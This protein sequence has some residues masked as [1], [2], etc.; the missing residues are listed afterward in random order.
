MHRRTP[1]RARI[2]LA[3]RSFRL[4]VSAIVI[5]IL[6]TACTTPNAAVKSE[7]A[8][9]PAREDG[10]VRIQDAS[11]QFIEV[12]DVTGTASNSTVTAPARVDFRDGAVSQVG[13]PLEG[14]V[15][16]VHVLVGQ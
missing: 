2:L 1:E 6:T 11:R 15:I 10:V 9:P 3:T 8:P 7:Q 5:G 4:A 16:K 13:V 12:A 14:R